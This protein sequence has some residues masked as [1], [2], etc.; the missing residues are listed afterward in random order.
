M[1]LPGATV[2]VKNPA[3]TYYRYEGLVQRVSDGKVAVLFEGGNWDKLVT[4][5]LSELELVET[6]AGRKKAK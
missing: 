3:D 5:R 4:F 6:T 2:R 1:I